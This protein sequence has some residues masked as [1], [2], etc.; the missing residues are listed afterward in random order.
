MTPRTQDSPDAIGLMY[1]W[2]CQHCSSMHKIKWFGVSAPKWTWVPTHNREV[3]C[4]WYLVIFFQ[5]NVT[6]YINHTP[7]QAIFSGIVI[8]HKINLMVFFY[9][10]F[11][12]LYFLVFVCLVF[13]VFCFFDLIWFDFEFF[14]FIFLG[15]FSFS[16]RKTRKEREHEDR[17]LGRWG[18]SGRSWERRQTWS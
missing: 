14:Y 6:W 4:N 13:V 15:G 7:G 3:S 11:I 8:Q 17:C 10:C 18:G 5:W 1:I 2:A 16:F 12:F 9:N